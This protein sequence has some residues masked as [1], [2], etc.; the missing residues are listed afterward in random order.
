MSEVEI[1]WRAEEMLTFIFHL[2]QLDVLLIRYSYDFHMY[3]T[4]YNGLFVCLFP[5]PLTGEVA[6]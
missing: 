3:C 2:K 1:E 5:H 4:L 6:E